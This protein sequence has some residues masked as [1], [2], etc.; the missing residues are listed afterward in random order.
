MD[1]N[2]LYTDYMTQQV[3]SASKSNAIASKDYANSTDD[4]LLEAC[5]Q[6]ESYFVEQSM[7]E[8]MKTTGAEDDEVMN[9]QLVSY[10]MDSTIQTLA[11]D[12]TDQGTLGLAQKLYQQ[13]KCNYG[14]SDLEVSTE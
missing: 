4:E 14:E 10:F 9:N 2:A 7:K 1:I 13:M 11:S 8:A 12:V 5:K 3:S 6:F